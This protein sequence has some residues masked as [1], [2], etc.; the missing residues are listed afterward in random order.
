M[1]SATSTAALAMMPEVVCGSQSMMCDLREA[2]RLGLADDAPHGVDRLD[3]PLA[4]GGLARQHDRVRA[5]Q[6]RVG[7]VGRLGARRPR[8]AD[9]RLEHLGG[10][11]HRLGPL[12]GGGDDRFCTSGTSSSGSST[13]RS[14]RATMMASNASDDVVEAATACGFSILAMTGTRRP[15]RP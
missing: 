9:H 2:Q 3:R 1:R 8:G 12:A 11:D 4:D 13:P 15:P 10:D 7:D 14:P 5:V 6:D